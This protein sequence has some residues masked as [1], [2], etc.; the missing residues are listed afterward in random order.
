MSNQSCRRANDVVL[1]HARD[2]T[3]LLLPAFVF[4]G[5]YEGRLPKTAA[6]SPPAFTLDFVTGGADDNL[7]HLGLFDQVEFN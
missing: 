1:H 5:H 3:P 7:I 2:M 4:L 6:P